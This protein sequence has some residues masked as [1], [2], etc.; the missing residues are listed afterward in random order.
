M[1][2]CSAR[3][4]SWRGVSPASSWKWSSVMSGVTWCLSTL[5]YRLEASVAV[6]L[7]SKTVGWKHQEWLQTSNSPVPQPKQLSL[8]TFQRQD[9][10]FSCTFKINKGQCSFRFYNEMRL[11]NMC[12]VCWVSQTVEKTLG[13]CILRRTGIFE[14]TNEPV[15]WR[16]TR[17]TVS[18]SVLPFGF[19][20]SQP[21]VRVCSYY[22]CVERLGQSLSPVTV[23]MLHR[24]RLWMIT[25]I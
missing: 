16:H 10:D 5:F 24:F 11:N 14:E 12:N 21:N 17:G 9:M 23:S 15:D 22:F 8:K 18:G 25:R 19:S 7:S 20:F 4:A 6:Y 2:W 3:M 1:L 13:I